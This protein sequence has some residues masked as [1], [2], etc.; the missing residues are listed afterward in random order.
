V[1]NNLAYNVN[2]F[3]TFNLRLKSENDILNG[4][5]FSNHFKISDADTSIVIR[6]VITNIAKD[7]Q[8]VAPWE[9]TRVPTGG[10]VFFPKGIT[11][12]V[13][14]TNK[15]RPLLAVRDVKGI[16]WYPYDSSQLSPQKLMMDGSEGWLAYVNKGIIFIKKYPVI[17]PVQAAPGE[18]NVEL[19]VNKEK[20]F[21]E[22]EN[23]GA[24]QKLLTGDSLSYEVKWY[25]R[26]VP[27]NLLNQVGNMK[28][29]EFARSI[30][31]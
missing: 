27:E 15:I 12:D 20:T 29:I 19:Y 8:E 28:L 14:L 9:V 11:N 25:V 22:L 5:K 17:K 18:K 7:I 13:P 24:Y 10:L 3:N 21:I 23:Q 2:F 30:I 31:E 1:L 16:I 26:R 6:Y 4:F